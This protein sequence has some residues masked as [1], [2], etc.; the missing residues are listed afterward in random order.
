MTEKTGR[1]IS[2]VIPGRPPTPNVRRHWREVYRDNKAWAE[3]ARLEAVRAIQRTAGWKP[4]S[5][6][7]VSVAFGVK[8]RRVRD[9][10]NLIASIKPLLD[11]LVQAGILVDDSL[12][13]ITVMEFGAIR[14]E[15][16]Q[17]AFIIETDG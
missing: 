7:R 8:D 15:E 2:I 17:T 6:A 10:D 16:D 13:V 11:G 14:T 5:R 4:A 1:F 9:L 3:T 12:D